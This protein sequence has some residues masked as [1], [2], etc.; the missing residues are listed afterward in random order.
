MR[1]FRDVLPE[2]DEFLAERGLNF[3]GTIIGGAALQ[4]LSIIERLTKDCDVLEPTISEEVRRAA[5]EFGTTHGLYPKWLNN[6][7]ETLQR[8]LPAG[9]E[10]RRQVAY[11]GKSLH[12]HTLGRE[13]L[14]RSKLFAYLDRGIDL[15]D[16]KKLKPTD[17]ELEALTPWLQERDGNPDWPQHVTDSLEKLR[18]ELHARPKLSL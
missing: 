12:L 9:W 15:G 2:F 16:L 18:R 13:D 11:R 14:L 4:L 8:D 3:S 7:P 5:E 17:T 6:G 1:Q 10:E